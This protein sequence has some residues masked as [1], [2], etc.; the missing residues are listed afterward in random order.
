MQLKRFDAFVRHLRKEGVLKGLAE[1]AEIYVQCDADWRDS[2]HAPLGDGIDKHTLAR[3]LSRKQHWRGRRSLR[4]FFPVAE[5]KAVVSVQTATPC[6]AETRNKIQQII[7]D[8][9][10]HSSDEFDALH[11]GLTGLANSRLIE[12]C[13]RQASAVSIPATPA[14]GLNLLRTIALIALDIDHFKQINDSYG[15]DYGDL[16]LRCFAQRLE[17]LRQKFALSSPISRSY[18]V[19]LVVKSS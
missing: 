19:G 3:V 2:Q 4:A 5:L 7:A 12:E 17:Q 8:V 11:D 1:L 10:K 13:V 6:R 15:H 18:P 14:E 16:V 9:L